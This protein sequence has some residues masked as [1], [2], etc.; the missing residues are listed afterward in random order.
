M[1]EKTR[2]TRKGNS[3]K[4][5]HGIINQPIYRASTILYKDCEAFETRKGVKYTYGTSGTPTTAALEE[6]LCDLDQG[7]ETMLFSSGLQAFAMVILSFVKS[8]EHILVPDNVYWPLR[9]VCLK[10][11]EMW[12]INTDYYAYDVGEGMDRLFR[13]NTKLVLM[14]SPGSLSFEIADIPA[15]AKACSKASILSV[16]DN[17]WSSGY[18]F[19]PLLLGVDISL[20]ATT[21]YISGH[22]DVMMGHV[23]AR[24]PEVGKILRNHRSIFG[25]CVSPDESWLALRGLR[26]LAPRLEQHQ[27][28]ALKVAQFLEKQPQIHRMLCPMLESSP[29]HALWKRDFTGHCGLFAFTLK[30]ASREALA[31]MID[32]MEIFGLGSSWGSFSSLLTPFQVEKS[33]TATTWP[34][35]ES[36]LRI[37][38]GLEDV[39]DLIDDLTAGLERLDGAA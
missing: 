24:D 35:G 10:L 25:Y 21:K 17:T 23:T 26:S 28:S 7:S 27:R 5:H 39:D 4:E 32:G 11:K 38:V 37:H 3:P 9:D 33:R 22:A 20:M 29:H 30:N 15:M 13:D 6:A 36:L 16:I 12:N 31:S 2:I 19:K 18:F 34:E 14:E 8:G 1:K